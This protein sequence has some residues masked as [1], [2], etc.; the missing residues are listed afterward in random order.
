[1]AYKY[2]PRQPVKIPEP[3]S[4]KFKNFLIFFSILILVYLYVFVFSPASCDNVKSKIDDTVDKNT[5]QSIIN[6]IKGVK[7]NEIVD[8]NNS[9]TNLNIPITQEFD[10][11]ILARQYLMA[12]SIEGK[13][14]RREQFTTSM[15]RNGVDL[16]E[17]KKVI[18]AFESKGIFNFQRAQP[19]HRFKIKMSNDGK[20][21][22]Y[23]QYH[24]G[25][26]TLYIAQKWS[27]G[28]KAK[29]IVHPI[30]TIVYGIGFNIK[31]NLY[32]SITSLK[33]RY[34]LVLKLLALFSDEI[35][36]Q[37]FST[38]D[39]IKFLIEKRFVKKKFLGYGTILS[40]HINTQARGEYKVYH[41]NKPG[42]YYTREGLSFFREFLKRPVAGNTPPENEIK[43]VGVIFPC[44]KS[45]PVYAVAKGEVISVKREGHFGRK[46][47]IKH[48]K[49]IFTSYYHLRRFKKNI[50][51]GTIVIRK[52][53]IGY[54]GYSGTT[55]D[56]NGVGFIARRGN[57]N[58]SLF[59]L[60]SRRNDPVLTDETGNYNKLIKK[61][62]EY[63]KKIDT[64]YGGVSERFLDFQNP[65]KRKIKKGKKGRKTGKRKKRR[66]AKKRR[67]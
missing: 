10:D 66:K 14:K 38:G 57:T 53:I 29:K 12:K 28:F 51:T 6:K 27:K 56:K 33:E 48:N 15:V 2:L 43:T 36:S 42:G 9:F 1:M 46:I 60:S 59:S 67:K 62:D 26:R 25:Y 3:G 54:A 32:T 19:G 45:P 41:F 35:Q 21:V 47:T 55:P 11:K 16:Q 39:S 22:F 7:K 5:K 18:S 52:Q 63:L 20:Q 4:K 61:Y 44:K 24:F 40:V 37:E 58:I 30:K 64:K 31:K 23:F 49:G 17:A 65:V 13:V 8:P 34:S 50:K